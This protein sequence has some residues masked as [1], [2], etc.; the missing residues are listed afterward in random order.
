[1]YY[2]FENEKKKKNEFRLH[3]CFIWNFT[4]Q[5]CRYKAIEKDL[6]LGIKYYGIVEIGH[7]IR[8]VFTYYKRNYNSQN[9]RNRIVLLLP[10]ATDA[11]TNLNTQNKILI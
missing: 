8:I 9:R 1:M 6:L 2:Y 7:F 10:M 3:K 5:R 11:Y 4:K